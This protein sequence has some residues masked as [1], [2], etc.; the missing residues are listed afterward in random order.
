MDSPTLREHDTSAPGTRRPAPDFTGHRMFGSG[1]N[2]GFGQ[3]RQNLRNDRD[4]GT[5][6][7]SS[8]LLRQAALAF[9][10]QVPRRFDL[11]GTCHA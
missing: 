6:G 1:L 5:F 11:P 4:R 7:T 3:R 10:Q 8:R 2:H 9:A